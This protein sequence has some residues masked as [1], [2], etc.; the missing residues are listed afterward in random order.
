MKGMSCP[1]DEYFTLDPSLADPKRLKKERDKARRLRKSS[2]W[3]K[4]IQPGLCHYCGRSF[5]PELLTMDHVVPL[6]RG[7]ETTPGNVVP[8][9]SACNR[10]K[11]LATPVERI[12]AQLQA[13]REDG[14]SGREDVDSA[15]AWGDAGTRFFLEL[16]PDRV[17]NAV[18]AAGLRC[19]GRCMALNSFENRVYDVDLEEAGTGEDSEGE[20]E[21]ERE[22]E[23]GK[24]PGVPFANRR[25]VKFYRPGRWS[26][27]QILE[28]HRF[29][30]DL[31]EAEI[32][33]VYPLPFPDG[34]TLR[35]TGAAEG[36]I[37]YAL[38]PKVGGR[39][40]EELTHEQLARV[41]RLLGRI[42]NVGAA[43][44]APHRLE[45]SVETYGRRSLEVLLSGDWLPPEL[46]VPYQATVEEICE[47]AG[48]LFR[49]TVGPG[50]I[51]RIHG[52]CHS[53]NLLWNQAGPFF[54]DFDDMLR[55]PAVQDIWLLAP[56]RDADSRASREALLEG[57][58]EMRAFDRAQLRLIESLRALRFV[59][60]SAWL[61]R[62][63]GD[64]AFPPAFPRFG[65]HRYWGDELRDLEEQL[66]LIKIDLSL[67]AP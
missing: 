17:L 8:A 31:H 43:R 34:A 27:R 35:R 4:R 24:S 45:L 67:I 59:H 60:Y 56:G 5:P 58:A 50:G 19:T 30:T 25:V 20:G 10:D 39:A 66:R 36:G 1:T 61:A 29:L 32:P 2:W 42:H 65:T 33:V 28:E 13:E 48:R 38:F 18:E 12:L 55:G 46:R 37:W 40:P 41:G 23:R 52:D 63:W 54:L 26:E 7:G 47:L 21:G 6:A 62:R 53:G 3:R 49:E 9:C 64:P 14:G 16:T 44:G 22:P 11:R 51:H 15:D 57:Y